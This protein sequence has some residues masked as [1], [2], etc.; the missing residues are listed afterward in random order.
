MKR[1]HMINEGKQ[2][3]LKCL[4]CSQ[5]FRKEKQLS[6]HHCTVGERKFKSRIRNKS[7]SEKSEEGR[8]RKDGGESK[9]IEIML[10]PFVSGTGNVR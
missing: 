8:G 7:I 3:V 6:Q 2:Q 4:N 10:V 9:N 1:D 5:T